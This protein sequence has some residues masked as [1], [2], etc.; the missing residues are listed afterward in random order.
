LSPFKEEGLIK[1]YRMKLRLDLLDIEANRPGRIQTV[2]QK[3]TK[4]EKAIQAIGD[5]QLL[6]EYY[7]SM[8]DFANGAR[9]YEQALVYERRSLKLV[10]SLE[11]PTA[12]CLETE[13]S[14]INL[15]AF[16]DPSNSEAE[17]HLETVKSSLYVPRYDIGKWPKPDE[18]NYLEVLQTEFNLRLYQGRHTSEAGDILTIILEKFPHSPYMVQNVTSL[19][20]GAEFYAIDK[21]QNLMEDYLKQAQTLIEAVVCPDAQQPVFPQ[22]WTGTVALLHGNHPRAVTFEYER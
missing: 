3:A 13:I 15:L 7:A 12:A 22:G 6:Y 20:C 16:S 14:I 18:P 11:R 8:S 5:E 21:Q 10:D 4:L 2:L 1:K 19:L 17:Q 9:D